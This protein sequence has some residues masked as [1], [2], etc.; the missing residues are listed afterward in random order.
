VQGDPVH[1][2]VLRGHDQKY[3]LHLDHASLALFVMRVDPSVR[4]LVMSFKAGDILLDQE[5]KVTKVLVVDAHTIHARFYDGTYADADAV[6]T[7]FEKKTIDWTIGHAPMSPDVFDPKT[8][9]VVMNQPVTDSELEGY[10]YYMQDVGSEIAAREAEPKK[11][12]EGFFARFWRKF[13]GSA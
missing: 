3:P 2:E 6:K 1:D 4:R 12:E 8:H 9:S 10:R 13:G 11:K 5:G 7:A